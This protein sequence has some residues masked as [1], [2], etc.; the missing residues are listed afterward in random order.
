VRIECS[1]LPTALRQA[2]SLSPEAGSGEANMAVLGR[3]SLGRDRDSP[4][5]TSCPRQASSEAEFWED[6]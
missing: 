5:L 2:L 3:G 1:C 6:P 4:E